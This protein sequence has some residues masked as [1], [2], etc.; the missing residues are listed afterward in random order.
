MLQ[1]VERHALGRLD[2]HARQALERLD[3]YVQ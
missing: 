2:A 1:Q 3:Q